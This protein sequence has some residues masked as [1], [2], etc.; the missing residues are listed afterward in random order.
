VDEL[1]RIEKGRCYSQI[2]KAGLIRGVSDIRK[3]IKEFDIAD[4]GRYRGGADTYDLFLRNPMPP[5]RSK[6]LGWLARSIVELYKS[7]LEAEISAEESYE[8]ELDDLFVQEQ[9]KARVV[10]DEIFQESMMQNRITLLKSAIFVVDLGMA[11]TKCRA[12]N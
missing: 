3:A 6:E 11:L 12:A 7:L 9:K 10:S 5:P 2:R 4:D 8:K 1:I